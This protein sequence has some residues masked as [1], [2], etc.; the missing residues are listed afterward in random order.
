MTQHISVP[1]VFFGRTSSLKCVTVLGK[2]HQDVLII[3]VAPEDGFDG[4]EANF[5][6][7][8]AN[9]SMDTKHQ[10]YGMIFVP[11]CRV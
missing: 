5:P 7:E 9:I 1:T 10:I 4:E 6:F 3:L 2:L 8:L 11:E